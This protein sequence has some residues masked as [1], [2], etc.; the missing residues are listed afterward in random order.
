MSVTVSVYIFV[1]RFCFKDVY[2]KIVLGGAN[3][4]ALIKKDEGCFAYELQVSCTHISHLSVDLALEQY[5]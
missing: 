1:L 4:K 5:S 2:D 3:H